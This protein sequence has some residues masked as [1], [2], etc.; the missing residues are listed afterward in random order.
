[1]RHWPDNIKLVSVTG[2]DFAGRIHD[3]GDIRYYISNW[4]DVFD[5]DPKSGR[6]NQCSMEEIFVQQAWWTMP[7]KLH[8]KNVFSKVF[9]VW[10]DCD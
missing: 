7:A 8:M 9:Y 6:I 2:I 3:V 10:L 1:M 4:R 5:I